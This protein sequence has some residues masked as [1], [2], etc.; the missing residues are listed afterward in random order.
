MTQETVLDILDKLS[1]GQISGIFRL[2]EIAEEEIA[3]AQRE[4]GTEGHDAIWRSFKLLR[5]TPMFEKVAEQVFRS[6]CK[7][8]LY[9]VVNGFDT[10]PGTKAEVMILIS[11]ASL[12]SMPSSDV[13]VLYTQL[14]KEIFGERE[15][16]RLV[17][18]SP[19]GIGNIPSHFYATDEILN[20]LRKKLRQEDRR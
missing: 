9:R 7:E 5:P 20:D 11:E 18:E 4:A 16:E 8:L 3:I 15:Y 13:R 6:H 17:E 19:W 10:R 14:F 2:M 12:A 1:L